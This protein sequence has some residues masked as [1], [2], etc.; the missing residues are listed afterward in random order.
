MLAAFCFTNSEVEGLMGH[1]WHSVVCS[2]PPPPLFWVS[3]ESSAGV[4]VG[5][6]VL[7]VVC[8]FIVFSIL[9][10][11]FRVFVTFVASTGLATFL[12]RVVAMFQFSV[13]HFPDYLK[14]KL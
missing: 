4:V 9:S 12:P 13:F 2:F 5:R 1:V 8:F 11:V 3:S 7:G 10:R 6:V 14:Y